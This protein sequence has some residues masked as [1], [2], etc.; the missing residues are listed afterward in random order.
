MLGMFTKRANSIGALTGA[1]LGAVCL[2]YIQQSTKIHFLLYAPSGV[3][4]CFICGYLLSI[5]VKR[6]MKNIEG[7]TIYS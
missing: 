1:G 5:F 7:L 4:I 6:K 2:A 3:I